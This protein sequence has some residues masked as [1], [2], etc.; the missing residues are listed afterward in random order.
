MPPDPSRCL[1]HRRSQGALRRQDKFHV[2]YF[3]NHDGLCQEQPSSQDLSFSAQ[4]WESRLCTTKLSAPCLRLTNGYRTKFNKEETVAPHILCHTYG[5]CARARF[6]V[7][8][9]SKLNKPFCYSQP[10]R[11]LHSLTTW[12][13]RLQL[14]Q[15]AISTSKTPTTC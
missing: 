12:P 15:P 6:C 11:F 3:H 10:I 1:R 8:V 7:I 4:T 2:R 9:I 13:L 14:F 5:H